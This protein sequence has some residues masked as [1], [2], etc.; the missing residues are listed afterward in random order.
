M[1]QRIIGTLV[2]LVLLAILYALTGAGSGDTP[3]D[4]LPAPA[5]DSNDRDFKDLKIN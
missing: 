1:K 5:F 4:S 2:L 3:A